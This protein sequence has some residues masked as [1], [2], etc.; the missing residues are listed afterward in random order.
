M[1]SALAVPPAF[2]SEQDENLSPTAVVADDTDITDGADSAEQ[3]DT[4]S[5]ED[6]SDIKDDTDDTDDVNRADTKKAKKTSGI[7]PEAITPPARFSYADEG[8][9]NL[10]YETV[11]DEFWGGNGKP[12]YFV[13]IPATGTSISLDLNF[14]P[15]SD[16]RTPST[17]GDGYLDKE[18]AKI[19][20]ATAR[21]TVTGLT[22]QSYKQRSGLEHYVDE[23][24]FEWSAVPRA[25]RISYYDNKDNVLFTVYAYLAGSNVPG[26]TVQH[27]YHFNYSGGTAEENG[28]QIGGNGNGLTDGTKIPLGYSYSNYTYNI[29]NYYTDIAD[30][31]PLKRIMINGTSFEIP[32]PGTSGEPDGADI[33]IDLIGKV[34]G[35]FMAEHAAI[36]ASSQGSLGLSFQNVLALRDIDIEFVFATTEAPRYRVSDT[37]AV[38]PADG[39]TV[40]PPVFLWNP[41][42]ISSAWK[43]IAKPAKGYAFDCWGYRA[44]G[45]TAEYTRDDASAGKTDY[46]P[47]IRA[48]REYIAYFKDL[49]LAPF[50][51]TGN[52][53]IGGSHGMAESET[54]WNNVFQFGGYRQ[55]VSATPVDMPI[56]TGTDKEG[57][58]LVGERVGFVAE[59]GLN[60]PLSA[61]TKFDVAFYAGETT[62]GAFLSGDKGK[63]GRAVSDAGKFGVDFSFYMPGDLDAITAVLTF[64]DEGTVYTDTR[65]FSLKEEETGVRIREPDDSDYYETVQCSYLNPTYVRYF[66]VANNMEFVFQAFEKEVAKSDFYNS[67]EFSSDGGWVNWVMLSPKVKDRP[68][69]MGIYGT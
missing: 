34:P 63:V 45:S 23:D 11:A 43:L 29:G 35:L 17:N 64:D 19:D 31:H 33:S 67:W 28:L 25:A 20:S 7:K 22:W 14:I 55:I 38:S 1:L 58:V 56:E 10:V 30:T 47:S 49:E 16:Y 52:Y 8:G 4:E 57:E 6:T 2:A 68:T 59:F 41:D 60:K 61:Y 21:L 3:D 40:D 53:H 13:E 39:G 26:A 12:I 37:V 9:G 36:H 46:R 15:K 51:F 27:Y 62:G 54:W 18:V 44:A 5:A 32:N 48:N 50:G 69:A 24:E 66:K 42:S 65:T